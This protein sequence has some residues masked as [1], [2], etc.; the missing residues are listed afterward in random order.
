[1]V[2]PHLNWDKVS[3]IWSS[4]Y[5]YQKEI[6]KVITEKTLLHLKVLQIQE[7]FTKL[8]KKITVWF[9]WANF[10]IEKRITI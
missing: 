2:Q 9:F 4:F 10:M 5:N 3:S 8:L 1:M 6:T 7:N